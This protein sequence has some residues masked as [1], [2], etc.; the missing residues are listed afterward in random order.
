V[1]CCGRQ[2]LDPEDLVILHALEK[3][4]DRVFGPNGR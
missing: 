1:D 3:T 4:G 2:T